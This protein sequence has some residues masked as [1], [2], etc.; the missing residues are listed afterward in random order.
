M[1]V[2]VSVGVLALCAGLGTNGLAED[3]ATPEKTTAVVTKPTALHTAYLK[4]FAFLKAEKAAL[5]A[6]LT[7]VRSKSAE[8]LSAARRDIE[9]LEGRVI[10]QRRTAG[11]TEDRLRDAERG[12]EQ[13]SRPEVIYE[14]LGR[15]REPLVAAGVEVSA[16]PAGRTPTVPETVSVIGETFAGATKLLKAGRS[17]HKEAAPF[18]LAD[19]TRVQGEILYLGRVA[20]YGVSEQGSGALAPAGAGMFRIWPMPAS[21]TAKALISGTRPQALRVFLFESTDKAIEAKEART[22]M[23][24]IRAGGVVAYVIV[25]LGAVAAV[26]ILVRLLTLLMGSLKS[27]EVTEQ[28]LDRVRAGQTQAAIQRAQRHSGPIARILVATLQN[29]RVARDKLDD[30]V[31]EALLNETP[32]LERFGTAI[33]VIA[34]VAPLLG[35]LGT[36]TGMIATFDVITEFGT[37]DP[38]MLSGGISEALIT[39]KLGLM[40]A[41]PALLVGTLLSSWADGIINGLEHA[42]LRVV[43]A[44]DGMPRYA[45]DTEAVPQ[46]LPESVGS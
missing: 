26:M 19:G 12:A 36:V 27:S 20:A 43:N 39:T 6:R 38:R 37:G 29:V 35:L 40:V 9:Q 24:E 31:Q 32:A 5:E 45:E 7:E 21:E 30:V 34:A 28:V 42:S 4:E 23:D 13:H 14:T 15:A 25:C 41:I 3:S 18:F 16:L 10:G 22:M 44:H 8:Q 33:T 1:K 46:G 11:Q 17:V 2:Y